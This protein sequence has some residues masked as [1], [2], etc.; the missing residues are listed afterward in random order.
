MAARCNYLYLDGLRLHARNVGV[1]L[2]RGAGHED[3]RLRVAGRAGRG[4][5]TLERL[6]QT[7]DGPVEAFYLGD[8]GLCIRG[9]RLDPRAC[10]GRRGRGNGAFDENLELLDPVARRVLAR[11]QLR[12][13]PYGDGDLDAAR[14]RLRWAAGLLDAETFAATL[15]ELP[16]RNLAVF[17]P[18]NGATAD[19][20]GG[21]GEWDA[22]IVAVLG[23]LHA[24]SPAAAG[25]FAALHPPGT[26]SDGTTLRFSAGG[27]VRVGV[28]VSRLPTRIVERV[29]ARVEKPANPAP[30]PVRRGRKNIKS[31]AETAPHLVPQWHPTRN[32]ALTP[33][34]TGRG[35]VVAV[36][37][38]CDTCGTEWQATPGNRTSKAARGCPGCNGL[39]A[40]RAANLAAEHPE[41]VREWHPGN[42]G[43]PETHRSKS[44]QKVRWI[45]SACSHVWDAAIYARTRGNGCPACAGVVVTAEHSLAA[46][47]PEIAAHW[48]EAAEP[49]HAPENVS[50]GSTQQVLWGCPTN[51]D[52]VFDRTVAQHVNAGGRCPYCTNRRVDDENCLAATHPELAEEWGSANDLGPEDV[53]AGSGYR[54]QWVCRSCART[55]RTTVNSRAVYGAGCKACVSQVTSSQEIALRE[56]LLDAGI[57]VAAEGVLV[58]ARGR[59]WH[60]D[61]VSDELRLVVEFDGS[62]WHAGRQRT[63]KSK[64]TAL[65]R[66]G[67][68][69]IR[70]REAPLRALHPHDVEVPERDDETAARLTLARIDELGLGA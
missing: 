19:L 68:T 26:G 38:L 33:E 50:S 28:D 25:R 45:C 53:V 59:E 57:P 17:D 8:D 7:S 35:S 54:A 66:D 20:L 6:R 36:W 3:L 41:L 10:R 62:Y 51:P 22:K 34:N 32:G 46:T 39:R 43:S 29:G 27:S 63:D 58:E 4:E 64:G 5:I 49:G 69:V 16:A 23:A 60:C 18:R 70:V 67:W 52:H 14:R 47:H 56:A 55:W 40:S 37:W 61:I 24:A 2:D 15:L 13:L 31:I 48:L 42:D 1:R 12:T 11:Q 44:A 65:R 30:A 9:L 21:V